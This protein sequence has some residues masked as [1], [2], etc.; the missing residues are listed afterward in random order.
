MAFFTKLFFESVEK[1][2]KKEFYCQS[3]SLN[4]I[5]LSRIAGKDCSHLHLG[6][7]VQDVTYK[8]DGD[9]TTVNKIAF[10]NKLMR[11]TFQFLRT[12]QTAQKYTAWVN[13]DNVASIHDEIKDSA[14]LWFKNGQSVV[15]PETSSSFVKKAIVYQGEYRKAQ[16]EKYGKART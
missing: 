1:Q 13:L 14:F 10:E 12:D 4:F 2:A 7:G 11:T 9:P 8:I 6:I 16:K 15:L 5:T 3:S